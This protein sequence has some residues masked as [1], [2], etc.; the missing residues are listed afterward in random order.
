MFEI[1]ELGDGSFM[2]NFF[3]SMEEEKKGPEVP[4]PVWDTRPIDAERA[5]SAVRAMCRD[6][7]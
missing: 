5:I 4:P 2:A 3:P 7:R 6:A 1:E